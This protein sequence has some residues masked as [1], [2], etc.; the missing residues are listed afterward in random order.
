MDVAVVG[1]ANVDL[2]T[3][4]PKTAR[5]GQTVFGTPLAMKPGGKGLNQAMSVVEH[6][7][8]AALVG[9]AGED[10]WG[11]LLLDALRAL[12][13]S[14]Y[15]D[16]D[17]IV[18]NEAEAHEI[19]DGPTSGLDGPGLAEAL[20]RCGPPAAVVT[21][22]ARGAAYADGSATGLVAAARAQVRDTTGAGDAFLGVAALM[23]ARGGTIPEA[24]AAGNLAGGVAVG[25]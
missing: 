15:A 8:A 18:V 10:A 3:H 21:L 9:R 24:V 13:Q 6:G 4:V 12:P 5:D 20:L 7:G 17:V 2:V 19:L 22:G 11:H 23:L 16:L 1:V 14:V 25:R